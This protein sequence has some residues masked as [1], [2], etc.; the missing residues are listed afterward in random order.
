MNSTD[1][2][3]NAGRDALSLVREVV[4]QDSADTAEVLAGYTA[5]IQPGRSIAPGEEER[6]RARLD[7]LGIDENMVAVHAALMRQQQ[8]AAGTDRELAVAQSDRDAITARCHELTAKMRALEVERN[9]LLNQRDELDQKMLR[10]RSRAEI[11]A[12]TAAAFPRIVTGNPDARPEDV[13]WH[14]A[15]GRP[16][17]VVD[18]ELQRMMQTTGIPFSYREGRRFAAL[19]AH[20]YNPAQDEEVAQRY[21]AR[22]LS[23]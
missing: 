7:Y 11:A 17:S 14:P 16:T 15:W 13:G 23:R 2:A 20:P 8:A 12:R 10:L 4:E 1:T 9:R 5:D 3:A 19:N 6:F 18:M 21:D 22:Q